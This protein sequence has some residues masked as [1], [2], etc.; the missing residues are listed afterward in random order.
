MFELAAHACVLRKVPVGINLLRPSQ[1]VKVVGV[2]D[3]FVRLV[4]VAGCHRDQECKDDAEPEIC[5]RPEE[6]VV[7]EHGSVEPPGRNGRI[8]T[9]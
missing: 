2:E 9:L 4:Q 5:R 8:S 7:P 6:I 3:K 1:D